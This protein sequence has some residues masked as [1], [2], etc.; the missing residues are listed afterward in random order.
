MSHRVGWDLVPT[1]V[2]VC[3][4]HVY[5]VRRFITNNAS[6]TGCTGNFGSANGSTVPTCSGPCTAGICVYIPIFG[7]TY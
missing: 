4:V 1:A 2:R 6:Y 5:Y 7:Y 3:Y